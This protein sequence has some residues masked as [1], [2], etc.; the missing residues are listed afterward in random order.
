[1]M[2]YTASH[3]EAINTMD[4]NLQIIACAGSGKTWV[5][6]ERMVNILKSK[7]NIKPENT[8]AF[9]YQENMTDVNIP[10]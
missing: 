2:G 7:L 8:L 10:Q 6:S 5:I 9:T 3:I 1:L 4:D